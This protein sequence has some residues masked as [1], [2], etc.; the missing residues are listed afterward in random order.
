MNAVRSWYLTVAI[1]TATLPLPAA[2]QENANPPAA[3]PRTDEPTGCITCHGDPDLWEQ[4]TS[5]LLVT[6]ADVSKDIH[7]QKGIQCHDCHGGNSESLNLRQAH[8]IENGFQ[9]IATPA[10]I[11]GFCGRCHSDIETMRRYQP[12]PR[13]DQESE[14]WTS[15]HGKRLRAAAEQHQ[16]ALANLPE[17]EEPPPMRD[18]QVATCLECHSAGPRHEIIAVKNLNSPVYPTHVAET[19]AKCH[20][21]AQRMAGRIDQGR[22]LGHHQY[23][24]WKQSVH[25]QALLQKGDLSA[26]TCND[27]HGNHGALPPDADSVANACGTCHGKVAEL[28]AKT[29][30][31]HQFE[32]FRLPG[33]ATC[34]GNHQTL[35]PTDEM[36]GMEGEAICARCHAQQHY[37]ATV[38]G[39][40]TARAMRDGLE[41]LKQEI[42]RAEQTV[43]Q[44]ERIG[45]EVRGPKFELREA[46]EA[47]T[48]ARSQLHGFALEPVEKT[49]QEGLDVAHRVQ[50]RAQQAL[51]EH[52]NR[53]IWLAVS[54]LPILIVVVL[55][56]L[57][58]RSLPL[59]SPP[60]AGTNS[61]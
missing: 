46:H 31:K 44:A 52:A 35:S 60:T 25:G 51:K 48:N 29:K 54:I 32:E 7:W 38:L 37:G 2:A 40:Q 28:F 55:L 61:E 59:P 12:S 6:A 49:L 9:V 24:E 39:A 41:N 14:Y 58:I 8:A 5:H 47:L 22:P 13:I 16:A 30:M 42:A 10:D 57:Y 17:G 21:D 43:G 18:P 20:A 3:E 23:A 15:G 19:C 34:H 56:L 4:D 50:Q 1:V 11:P 45:M 27:C 36:L 53:R 26:P 33:C